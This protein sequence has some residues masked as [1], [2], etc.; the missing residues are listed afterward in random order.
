MA[1]ALTLYNPAD[2]LTLGSDW[3]IQNNNDSKTSQQATNAKADGDVK[4]VHN[5]TVSNTLTVTAKSC[6]AEGNLSLP[7]LTVKAGWYIENVRL[8]YS[9]VDYPTLSVTAHKHDNTAHPAVANTYTTALTFPAQ[10]GVPNKITGAFDASS[11]TLAMPTNLTFTLSC[12]HD[13]FSPGGVLAASGSRAGQETIELEFMGNPDTALSL[14]QGWAIISDSAA[15]SN[16]TANT[17]TITIT[18]Y[19]SK[20]A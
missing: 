13:D 5:H 8:V 11:A 10:F 18:R 9:G 14:S 17:R 1:E 15:E 4:C 12:A 7:T 16:S 20:D 19:I 6:K 2:I 3:E